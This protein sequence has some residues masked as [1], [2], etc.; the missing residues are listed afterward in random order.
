M[1]QN[2]LEEDYELLHQALKKFLADD[3]TIIKIIMKNNK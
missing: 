2:K 3:E 1:E